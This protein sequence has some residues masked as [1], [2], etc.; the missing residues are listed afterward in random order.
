VA[1]R[2]LGIDRPAGAADDESG[3]CAVCRGSDFG[4]P[5][6]ENCDLPL[7][8]TPRHERPPEEDC[9]GSDRAFRRMGCA[10]SI[11]KR[12]TGDRRRAL[13]SEIVGRLPGSLQ[14]VE[15]LPVTNLGRCGVCVQSA[16]PRP[17]GSTSRALLA[18]DDSVFEFH[19]RRVRHVHV[20]E[21][22][23]ALDGCLLGLEFIDGRLTSLD[24]PGEPLSENGPP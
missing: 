18:L 24:S 1:S 2:Q 5:S 3:S 19:V 15:T 7:H 13:R 22:G 16:G 21:A 9:G 8:A 12:A 20:A 17:I 23:E 4:L 6:D 14:T 11:L 10:G